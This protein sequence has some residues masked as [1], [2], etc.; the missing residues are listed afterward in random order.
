MKQ[1]EKSESTRQLLIDAAYILF[2]TNGLQKTSIDNI[3]TKVNLSRGAFYHHFKD[4]KELILAVI[5][6]KVHSRIYDTMISP[7]Y[8]EGDP[9]LLLRDTFSKRLKSFT[10]N[11]KELGCPL[12]KFITELNSYK[13]YNTAL[14]NT[15]NEWEK[16][17]KDI[18]IRAKKE[19]KISFDTNVSATA[20][21]LI[22]AYEGI[23]TIRKIDENDTKLNEFIE[24]IIKYIMSL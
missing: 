24:I 18:L 22:S 2:Y 15:I 3:T 10:K 4:K 7:L 19:Q 11:E 5:K 17:I 12:N 6:T 8:R 21:F 20:L 16:A 1:Q 9:V 13:Q 14:M 23:R